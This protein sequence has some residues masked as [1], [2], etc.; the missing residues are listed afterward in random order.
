MDAIVF[1]PQLKVIDFG[2]G[3]FQ[4]ATIN[5]IMDVDIL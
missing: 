3:L 2:W 4:A 5:M 1:W